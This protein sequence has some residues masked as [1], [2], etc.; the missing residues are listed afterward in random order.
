MPLTIL[1]TNDFHGTLNPPKAAVIR[2]MK[3]GAPE[4]CLYFDSGDCIKAGNLGVPLKPEEAWP[5]LAEA[6]C[7]ASVMGNRE[8]H[9]LEAAMRAKLNGAKHPVLAANIRTKDGHF[10]F[11]R[12]LTFDRDGIR[13]GLVGV[14]VPMVTERMATKAA[15]AY[16]WDL[17]IPTAVN[18]GHELRESVDVLIALTHIGSKQDQELAEHGL[19]DVILGGH[20]HTVLEQPVQVGRTYVCQGGSHGRYIGRYVWEDGKLSGGLVSL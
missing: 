4:P 17:P 5:L 20:S 19:F 13:I 3:D 8:T 12:T 14:M 18:L 10:P 7:D 9:V 15:S 6:R 2:E 16:L 11:Q 1:H